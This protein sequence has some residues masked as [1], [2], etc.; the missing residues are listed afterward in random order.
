MIIISYIPAL[1]DKGLRCF[2]LSL[3]LMNAAPHEVHNLHDT[4]TIPAPYVPP[5]KKCLRCSTS[6]LLASFSSQAPT[7]SQ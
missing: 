7:L 6:A 5:N 2:L 4:R 1:S 3:L